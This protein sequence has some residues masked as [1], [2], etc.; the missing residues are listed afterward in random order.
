MG[1]MRG[2]SKKKAWKKQIDI[3]DVEQRLEDDRLAE[4]VG[5]VCLFLY[6]DLSSHIFA[7]AV[8]DRHRS[9]PLLLKS[10]LPGKQEQKVCLDR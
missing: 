6:L 5:Y 7:F 2:K 9:Q 4:R 10:P 1:Q 3:S 8:Q